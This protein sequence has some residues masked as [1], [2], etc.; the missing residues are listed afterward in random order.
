MLPTNKLTST[1]KI[2]QCPWNSEEESSTLAGPQVSLQLSHRRA[3]QNALLPWRERSTNSPENGGGSKQEAIMKITRGNEQSAWFD[4]DQPRELKSYSKV[5]CDWM[6]FWS[7]IW[8]STLITEATTV[9]LRA[10]STYMR[11][12]GLRLLLWLLHS[13]TSP[14]AAV[15]IDS[16]PPSNNLPTSHPSYFPRHFLPLVAPPEFGR[17]SQ[18]CQLQLPQCGGQQHTGASPRHGLDG[19]LTRGPW[20]RKGWTEM[21]K[22]RGSKRRNTFPGHFWSVLKCFDG[23]LHHQHI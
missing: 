8:V 13:Y 19:L 20:S 23:R 4:F 22:D 14:R 18:P 2:L 16:F 6:I 17:T 21:L 12:Q 5:R 10:F 7:S 15:K 11:F 3:M 1:T 9:A